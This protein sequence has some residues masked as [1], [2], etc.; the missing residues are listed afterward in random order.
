MRNRNSIQD[1][2]GR[3]DQMADSLKWEFQV[4]WQQTLQQGNLYPL[5]EFYNSNEA[6]LQRDYNIS[7]N[8]LLGL[9]PNTLNDLAY[10]TSG[11][12][13]QPRQVQSNPITGLTTNRPLEYTGKALS[14]VAFLALAGGVFYIYKSLK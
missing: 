9:N 14:W 11:A 10:R 12:A 4:A 1:I 13:V 8:E 2:R 6:Q 7:L 5:V 3:F